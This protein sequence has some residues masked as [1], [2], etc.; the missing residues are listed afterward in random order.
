M[1]RH[2]LSG[3]KRRWGEG[4]VS[5]LDYSFKAYSDL[6][7]QVSKGLNE[8]RTSRDSGNRMQ[9]F[10]AEANAD[11]SELARFLMR[12]FHIAREGDK[13]V[14]Q[15]AE[16]SGD[17]T[18]TLPKG[19][20]C[21]LTPL[22]LAIDYAESQGAKRVQ[23]EEALFSGKMYAFYEAL[24]QNESDLFALYRDADP[25]HQ[26]IF[27]LELG[28]EMLSSRIA[29]LLAA[30]AL[31]GPELRIN[32]LYG[33]GVHLDSLIAELLRDWD[34]TSPNAYYDYTKAAARLYEQLAAVPYHLGNTAILPEQLVKKLCCL[35]ETYSLELLDDLRRDYD[36]FCATQQ[37][38][39]VQKQ[40]GAFR[41]ATERLSSLDSY[42]QVFEEET[43][44]MLLRHYFAKRL[45]SAGVSLTRYVEDEEFDSN[46]LNAFLMGRNRGLF[47]VI[48]EA[49]GELLPRLMAT[50]K[51]YEAACA[52]DE[53]Y[54][55]MKEGQVPREELNRHYAFHH[56][57]FIES[58]IKHYDAIFD[59]ETRV[60]ERH[61]F[62][63]LWHRKEDMELLGQESFSELWDECQNSVAHFF[64][65]PGMNIHNIY[66]LE[67]A[68]RFCLKLYAALIDGG[69]EGAID[70][71][72]ASR[73]H[74]VS[75]QHTLLESLKDEDIYRHVKEQVYQSM[76]AA[77]AWSRKE[78]QQ[79]H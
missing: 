30:L 62:Y 45:Q 74:S 50:Q 6:R 58:V 48:E 35:E 79:R 41:S 55:F 8:S 16:R 57:R 34:G 37:I 29:Q 11:E 13:L 71:T 14:R 27:S 10:L 59:G 17:R 7:R 68:T 36:A 38:A 75:R 31:C 78:T 1:D 26:Q 39:D 69:V 60:A 52:A 22:L 61:Q 43:E 32:R 63:I 25:F 9:A 56:L 76:S 66:P 49:F 51:M 70:R 33:I 28:T 64:A 20:P 77:V 40:A 53:A 21:E 5:P 18:D 73:E 3:Y 24:R 47:E 15:P 23:K 54:D 46:A 44:R 2:I 19:I 42:E 12:T 4:L 67:K 72:L 65:N